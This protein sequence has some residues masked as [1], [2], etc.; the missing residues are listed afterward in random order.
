MSVSEPQR[1]HF[2]A[3]TEAFHDFFLRLFAGAW[4]L[5]TYETIIVTW[6]VSIALILSLYAVKAWLLSR[7][8][9]PLLAAMLFAFVVGFCVPVTWAVC[10]EWG[11]P[12]ASPILICVGVPIMTLTVPCLSFAYDLIRRSYGVPTNWLFRVPMELALVPVGA[13]A[14]GKMIDPLVLKWIWI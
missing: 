5:V 11:D 7:V 13:L 10:P 1:P 3:L 4:P 12:W 8:A 9:K 2:H 14:W 6:I